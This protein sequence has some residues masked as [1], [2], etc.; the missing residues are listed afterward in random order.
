[1]SEEKFHPQRRL[2]CDGLFYAK[3]HFKVRKSAVFLAQM[4]RNLLKFSR[5]K[6]EKI[7][8]QIVPYTRSF[9]ASIY[10]KFAL[11]FHQ[12]KFVA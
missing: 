8:K 7:V 3:R 12:R 1:V 10:G 6:L 2:F 5:Q 11:G 9:S 4:R